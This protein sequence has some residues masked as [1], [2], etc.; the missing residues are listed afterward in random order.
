MYRDILDA[1]IVETIGEYTIVQVSEQ[2]Y[3][4]NG[5]KCGGQRIVH[6]VCL[7]G[8]DGD[9]VY[10]CNHLVEAECWAEEN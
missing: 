8:G 2:H 7:D 1:K 4:D 9:I 5:T 6:D 10:S 3:F